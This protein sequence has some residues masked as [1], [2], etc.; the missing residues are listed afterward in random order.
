MWKISLHGM[1]D[2][3]YVVKT[4]LI[5][6]AMQ[7]LRL[8]DKVD[9]EWIRSTVEGCRDHDSPQPYIRIEGRAPE[10]SKPKEIDVLVRILAEKQISV[11]CE[12]P[13]RLYDRWEMGYGINHP[14]EATTRK[15]VFLTGYKKGRVR[16]CTEPPLPQEEECWLLDAVRLNLLQLKKDG[17][18]IGNWTYSELEGRGFYMGG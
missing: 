6:R 14:R 7:E 5:K 1:D 13:H 9:I 8:R 10:F 2:S 16:V 4:A 3:E 18:Y 12:T 15:V 11:P 17:L